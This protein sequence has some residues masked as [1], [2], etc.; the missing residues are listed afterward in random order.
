[1]L[2]FHFPDPNIPIVNVLGICLKQYGNGMLI[3]AS[4]LNQ[5]E[6]N[7]QSVTEGNLLEEIVS[8]SEN[9][10]EELKLDSPQYFGF[11]FKNIIKERSYEYNKKNIR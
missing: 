10:W 7:I 4:K 2:Y 8:A 11:Q 3:D 1:M 9:V 5:L 6:Q